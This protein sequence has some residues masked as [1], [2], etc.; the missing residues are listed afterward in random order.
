M[1]KHKSFIN[2]SENPICL[3]YKCPHA[4][5]LMT[6]TYSERGKEVSSPNNHW[7]NKTKQIQTHFFGSHLIFKIL[8]SSPRSDFFIILCNIFHSQTNTTTWHNT[9][10][11]CLYIYILSFVRITIF[12]IHL[13]CTVSDSVK[14]QP[15]YKSD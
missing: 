6:E 1:Y 10:H 3:C 14:R 9:N 13:V 12:Y 15:L 11:I 5:N 2:K 8:L 4:L 7:R